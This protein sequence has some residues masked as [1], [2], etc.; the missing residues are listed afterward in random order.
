M[1][2]TLNR[3][4]VLERCLH[5]LEALETPEG[6]FQI[7]AVDNGSN[8]R[9]A[10]VLTDWTARLPMRRLYEGGKGK[11]IAL[12]QALDAVGPA[13]EEAELVVFFDDD[14]LPP[15]GWLVGLQAAARRCP[16]ADIFG[17]AIHV[18][19]TRPPPAW[20]EAFRPHYGVLFAEMDRAPGP[21][22]PADLWGPNLAVRGR[23]FARGLRF[24]D[25][26]GPNGRSDYAMGSETELLERLGAMG[27]QAVFVG[28]V[29]VG[30]MTDGAAVT[31]ASVFQRAARHGR[32][33]MR[34]RRASLEAG[35]SSWPPADSWRGL[36]A[37]AARAVVSLPGRRDLAWFGFF[38]NWGAFSEALK[39]RPP[40]SGLIPER[41][42]AGRPAEPPARP[43]PAP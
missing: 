2:S 7:I 15:K 35:P 27:S 4:P 19:W 43:A 38:W 11:N 18:V 34:R 16:A 1:V 8:D 21:C 24:N 3:A 20:L 6:G 42:G 10:E 30:H 9:T 31:K 23:C 41:S 13:I 40:S 29:G 26:F 22:S 32:G 25:A 28:E 36:L 5:S 17:G 37:S 12:N 33:V 39:R 14:V